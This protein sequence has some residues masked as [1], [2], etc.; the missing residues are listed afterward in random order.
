MQGLYNQL[1][2]TS[3]AHLYDQLERSSAADWYLLHRAGLASR[4]HNGT[5]PSQPQ[6]MARDSMGSFLLDVGILG[7]TLTVPIRTGVWREDVKQRLLRTQLPEY[8]CLQLCVAEWRRDGRP[9]AAEHPA[10][11]LIDITLRLAMPGLRGGMPPK[12][13][14]QDAPTV[15]LQSGN[16][17]GIAAFFSKQRSAPSSMASTSASS[18]ASSS[19]GS[20]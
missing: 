5:V 10:A 18:T 19:T 6:P 15:A 8:L 17:K 2:R 1:E 16:Q 7:T 9:L 3:V 12:Q 14:E 4:Q 11:K 13:K 20:S